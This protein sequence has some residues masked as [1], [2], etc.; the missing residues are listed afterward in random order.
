[1]SSLEKICSVFGSENKVLEVPS[2]GSLSKGLPA[3]PECLLIP[4]LATYSSFI[5]LEFVISIGNRPPEQIKGEKVP[6]RVRAST[7]KRPL[8]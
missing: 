7:F 3:L 4:L 2:P 1:L 5:Y 6:A 8:L